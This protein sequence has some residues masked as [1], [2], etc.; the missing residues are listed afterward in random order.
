[1]ATQAL[2]VQ[3]N[4]KQQQTSLSLD[5]RQVEA[6]I[7]QFVPVLREIVTNG[8]KLTDEQIRGRAMFAAING[9]D[10]VTEVHTITDN[11][12]KTLSHTMAI[13]GYR[14]KCQEQ[15]GYGN[16]ITLDFVEMDPATL[17]KFGNVLMGYECRLKDGASYT[18]WQKRLR[19]VGNA[20]REAMGGAVSFQDLMSVVGQ[21]P[22]YVGVGLFYQSELSEWKD[23]NFNPVERCK[24]RAELN[25]R[26]RRFPTNADITEGEVAPQM[27]NDGSVE[28]IDPPTEPKRTRTDIP[29]NADAI[30]GQLYGEP[31]Q[32]AVFRPEP[33]RETDSFTTDSEPGNGPEEVIPEPD[34]LIGDVSPEMVNQPAPVAPPKQRMSYE[35]AATV[36]NRDGVPYTD[37][38][39]D[40]LTHMSRAIAK[41]IKENGLDPEAKSEHLF[42][43]DAIA[44]IL[45][46]RSAQ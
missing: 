18:Q 35:M 3:E 13:D 28:I 30:M 19:E 12:G 17:K 21:P 34:E 2:A 10:P 9:L 6:Q 43:L 44:V 39:S 22:V 40:K 38:P 46:S 7:Q 32:S 29:T 45:Q 8:K 15:V 14:R 42:K 36:K 20:L 24:K 37:I 4:G 11:N 27:I 23:K 26:K 25:A 1:M 31:V 41:A 5:I 16:E 33:E